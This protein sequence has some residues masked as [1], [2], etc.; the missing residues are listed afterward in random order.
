MTSVCVGESQK[1]LPE[2]KFDQV[3]IIHVQSQFKMLRV[4]EKENQEFGLKAFP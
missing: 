3:G 1:F 4:G 2:K